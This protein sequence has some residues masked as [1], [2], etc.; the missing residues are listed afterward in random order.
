MGGDGSDRCQ[1]CLNGKACGVL[2]CPLKQLLFIGFGKGWTM[3]KKPSL[4]T[5]RHWEMGKSEEE[6]RV[7]TIL[8]TVTFPVLSSEENV[9]VL[10]VIS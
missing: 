4:S 6:R 7:Q 5:R 2:F 1:E 9:L 10:P 8:Y 3:E